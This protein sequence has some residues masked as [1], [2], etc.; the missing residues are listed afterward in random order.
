MSAPS[1][2]AAVL[3]LSSVWMLAQISAG[4][5][6]QNSASPQS[7][8][9]PDKSRATSD[10]AG[11]VIE[12]CLSGAA[13][14]F[15]LTDATGKTYELTGDTRGLADNV[16]HKVRLFGYVGSSGGGSAITPGGPQATFGVK[17]LQSLS[18]TCE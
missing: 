13:D 7:T 9:Q 12:G 10:K 5:M 4:S 15:K 16:G 18:S 3:L 6:N 8:Q 14:V 2:R 17:K 11:D 1:L